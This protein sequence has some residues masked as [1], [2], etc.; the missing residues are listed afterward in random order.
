MKRTIAL[1]AF[2]LLTLGGASA[3]DPWVSLCDAQDAL[4]HGGGLNACGCHFNR[5][6]GDCHCHQ[7]RGCGC[8]CQP[9]S[10]G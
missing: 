10:C 8:A 4:Q 9:A 5:K 7:R 2:T 1:I 6:T 3:S